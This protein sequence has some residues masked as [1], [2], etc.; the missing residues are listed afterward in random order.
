MWPLL[1]FLIFKAS[2]NISKVLDITS[3]IIFYET[4]GKFGISI[5]FKPIH[6]QFFWHYF[7]IYIIFAL[8]DLLL[9]WLLFISLLI[10]FELWSTKLIKEQKKMNW[11]KIITFETFI[12]KILKNICQ[13]QIQIDRD[14]HPNFHVKCIPDFF[15]HNCNH[16]C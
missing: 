13:Q 6:R 11:I 7:S 16:I 14:N 3:I 15:L 10:V 12:S 9:F 4:F 2:L 5:P 8:I 1:L